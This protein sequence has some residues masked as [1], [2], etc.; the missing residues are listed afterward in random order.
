LDVSSIPADSKSAGVRRLR[1]KVIG[2]VSFFLA[3]AFNSG[4]GH[5]Q[6]VRI[7]YAGLSGY[8]VPLWVTQEAGLF[9]KH[10]LSV[11]L[12]LIDG[13]SINIQVLLANEI[14]FAN[15]AGSAPIFARAHGAK[16]VIVASS[17]NFI[18]YSFVVNK[19]VRSVSDL[20]G[21]RIAITRLGG[22]TE[23]AASLAL[24]K[25]GLGAKDMSYFQVGA[26]SQ[27]ILA[28]QSG[29]VAAT[30]LAPPGLFTATAAGLKVLAD[31]SDLGVKYPT[32][33]MA[34]TNAYLSQNP[35]AVK[36][37]LMAF[38]EG[39][40]LYKQKRDFALAVM[41]KYTKIRDQEILAKTHDY[42][43]RNTAL[44]PL[45]DPV[46]IENALPADNTGGKRSVEEFYDNS[47]LRELVNE[48][49]VEKIAREMK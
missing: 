28:A 9:K 8:N 30:V 22:V 44:V 39:L 46:A 4:I 34:T 10:G 49:F 19:D 2:V 11:E 20:K 41:Q 29:S 47:M 23:V 40:H 43:V 25:L 7:S 18:P 14:R 42:F 31:L 21:K 32:A 17:Y 36:K 38:V 26:D 3:L 35:A 37:F 1:A 12:V 27:K 15:V 24:E 16:A 13:G 6:T 48:G 5:A 33:T 45:T